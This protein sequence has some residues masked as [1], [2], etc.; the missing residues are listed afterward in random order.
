MFTQSITE[1]VVSLVNELRRWGGVE[2]SSCLV[3]SIGVSFTSHMSCRLLSPILPT[4]GLCFR[5]KYV[6][7]IVRYKYLVKSN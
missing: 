4:D 3:F 7:H 1:H 5:P 6:A 2:N